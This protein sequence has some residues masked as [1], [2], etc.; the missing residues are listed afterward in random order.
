MKDE[1]EINSLLKADKIPASNV[2]YHKAGRRSARNNGK[3][4]L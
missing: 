2:Q 1:E 4:G 3:R